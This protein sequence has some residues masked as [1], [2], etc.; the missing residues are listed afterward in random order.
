MGTVPK[1]NIVPAVDERSARVEL[2]ALYRIVQ[3]MG[4]PKRAEEGIVG[5]TLIACPMPLFSVA[6]QLYFS[7]L[8]EGRGGQDLAA[9]CAVVEGLAGIR[10]E[11]K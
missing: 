11:R 3:H 2:A 7:A 5:R 1:N 6:M 4:W 8:N 10:R 9:I